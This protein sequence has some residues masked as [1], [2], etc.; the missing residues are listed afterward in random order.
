MR[1]QLH[2][3]PG[4]VAELIECPLK[5]ALDPAAYRIGSLER[6]GERREFWFIEFGGHHVWG[7]T[8]RILRAL[9]LLLADD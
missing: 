8:A 4:E 3:D 5:L 1:P 2:A 6:D 7:A 9:A